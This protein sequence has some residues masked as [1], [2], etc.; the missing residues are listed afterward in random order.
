M[1][2][3]FFTGLIIFLFSWIPIMMIK[4]A[5]NSSYPLPMYK[6]MQGYRPVPLQVLVNMAIKPGTLS[7]TVKFQ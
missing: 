5:F 1:K 6:Q 2:K 7:G 4:M 3:L